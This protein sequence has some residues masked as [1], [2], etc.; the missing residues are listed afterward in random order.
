MDGVS[1]SIFYFNQPG[2]DN[3][4]KVIEI[5]HKRLKE[6]DIRSVVV[7][8]SGGATGLKFAKEMARETNLVVVSTHP[9][10]SRPRRLDL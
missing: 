10:Y 1:R 6:G 7:A 4:D 9:G 2:I 3:T 5:V 8:S